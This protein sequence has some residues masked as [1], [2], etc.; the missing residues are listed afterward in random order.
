MEPVH[1]ALR[2][3]E[4][5]AQ[6]L[7]GAVAVPQRILEVRDP[8]PHVTFD[9]RVGTGVYRAQLLDRERKVREVRL[10]EVLDRERPG[11]PLP[12]KPQ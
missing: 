1:Q 2:A 6:T 5:E 9:A 11:Q 7:V 8:R 12:T 4:A 10:I 3:G